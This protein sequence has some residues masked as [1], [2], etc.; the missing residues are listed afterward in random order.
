MYSK[1]WPK[2]GL[3]GILHH[4]T[5]TLVT[6]EY[7]TQTLSQP[8][9][10]LFVGGLGD[11]LAT[12]SYMADIASALKSTPWSLFTLNLTSSYQSWGLG[13][14]DR[15]TD[16]IAQCIRYIQ[17]YKQSKYPDGNGKIVLM[18]HSTGS[19]CVMHYLSR[20]NPHTSKPA[21]DPYLEHVVR[22]PLDGA[23]MQAPVSDREAIG[24]VLEN[25]M[26]GKSGEECREVYEKIVKMAREA[27]RERLSGKGGVYDTMLPIEL[28]SFAYPANTPL[29][30]R[31]LLSLVS[32]D[33]PENPGED[34]M[35]SSDLGDEQLERTFGMVGK[36]GLLRGKLM[37]LHSGKDQS[38]P[39]WVDKEAL[40]R[41]WKGITNRGSVDGREIWDDEHTAVIPNASH[42][43]SNDDQAEPRRFLVEK[44]MGYLRMVLNV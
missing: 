27:E 14:L 19:Q 29:S 30:A 12:T 43:L 23:I 20:P 32:P 8:H 15:D 40:L 21:F 33:S 37:V 17:E 38:V 41:K 24:W 44:V 18:G 26:G 25:G 9:S 5:E 39:D 31:R 35:F 22:V 34:D 3:P 28:T 36:G 42:A 4:Y 2:G 7:T 6:F 13:H 11:G 1:F 16:E 10:L